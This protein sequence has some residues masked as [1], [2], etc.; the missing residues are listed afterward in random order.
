MGQFGQQD[1]AKAAALQGALDFK[2][3]ALAMGLTQY[4]QQRREE[5]AKEKAEEAAEAAG[6][7]PAQ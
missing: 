5:I 4:A 6:A 1:P 7:Q 2:G 3:Q